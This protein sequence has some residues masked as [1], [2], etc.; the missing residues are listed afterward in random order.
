MR[1]LTPTQVKKLD[2][3]T[4]F[5]LG[6]R[7]KYSGEDL[8]EEAGQAIL[9]VVREKIFGSA[10]VHR[11]KKIL[12][13]VGP[14]KN[15]CDGF[16]AA[17]LLKKAGYQN[18]KVMIFEMASEP[19]ELWSLQM[20]KAKT[21]GVVITEGTSTTGIFESSEADLIIDAIFGVGLSRPL[22]GDLIDLFHVINQRK[23]PVLAVDMPTGIHSNTGVAMGAAICAQWTVTFGLAKPGLLQGHGPSHSGQVIVAPLSYPRQ[24]VKDLAQTHFAFGHSSAQKFLPVRSDFS[25]KGDHGRVVIIAGEKYPGAAVLAAQAALRMGA[26]YVELV[27]AGDWTEYFKKIPEVLFTP[28]KKFNFNSAAAKK[29]TFVVGPG[30]GD[31]DFT[32]AALMQLLRAQHQRVVV[33][34]DGLNWMSEQSRGQTKKMW[35]THWVLTPHAKELSRLL[36]GRVS[37]LSEDRVAAAQRAHQELGAAILFKGYRSIFSVGSKSVIILSGNSGLAKAGSGDVLSGLIGTGVAQNTSTWTGAVLGAWMHGHLADEW[38]RAGKDR[39]SLNPSDLLETL[40][41]VLHKLR[42][43]IS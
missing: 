42:D 12:V 15:G 34:A 20:E 16:V 8:Q 32:E 37:E 25:N 3:R 14:G 33:D 9:S 31:S 26:G 10:I 30:Q 36:N 23:T 22:S 38:V 35:P 40:P 1:L 24:A 6:S 11:K 21:H 19:S 17:R 2:A 18:V 4:E 39:A 5:E 28:Q 27:S 43:P 13:L 7:G 29:S 41:G